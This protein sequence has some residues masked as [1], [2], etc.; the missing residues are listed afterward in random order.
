MSQNDS[1][2]D[3]L[4]ENQEEQSKRNMAIHTLV[5]N[6]TN[7]RSNFKNADHKQKV[8]SGYNKILSFMA[9]GIQD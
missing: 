6:L 5:G 9:R 3:Q 7:W 1:I 4:T 8:Y 2:L